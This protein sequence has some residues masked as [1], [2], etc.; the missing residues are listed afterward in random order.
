MENM[1][2]NAIKQHRLWH[3]LTEKIQD[4]L[5]KSCEYPSIINLIQ[6]YEIYKKLICSINN[7]LS[8]QKRFIK[9][10]NNTNETNTDVKNIYNNTLKNRKRLL[11][12]KKIIESKII[13]CK[14][15]IQVIVMYKNKSIV[16]YDHNHY[17]NILYNNYQKL[18]E[19][20]NNE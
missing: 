15:T 4:E 6:R 5:V 14:S 16:E 2:M 18:K 10:Y 7:R 9:R 17:Y 19:E 8:N 20:K 12:A 3:G 11:N 13:E 1:I